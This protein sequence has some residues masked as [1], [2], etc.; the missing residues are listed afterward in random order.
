[1]DAVG[2]RQHQLI[3]TWQLRLLGVSDA[4]FAE[5]IA[6]GRWT[7][8]CPNVIALPG[9]MTPVRHLAA[10]VLS[11]APPHGA[12]L[13]VEECVERGLTRVQAMVYAAMGAGQIVCG[14][15]ALWLHG[16]VA[17]PAKPWVRIAT[18]SAG[19]SG[20]VGA[21]IRYGSYAGA[22]VW[23]S[24]LPVVEVEQ[25]F[26]DIPGAQEHP[27]AVWLHHDLTRLIAAADAKRATT[28]DLLDAAVA[29]APRFV[30]A[31]AIRRAIA[32]L[33]GE[34]VHSATER[35]ARRL[36]EA[37]VASFGLLLHERPYLVESNGVRVGEADLALVPIMLD[38]E[39]DGPH[40]RLPTQQEKDRARDRA[41]RRAGWE[42]ERFPTELIDVSPQRF[43]A[44]VA[45]CIAARIAVLGLLG[46]GGG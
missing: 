28:L 14:R 11:L 37:V 17:A 13:R 41:M 18:K 25:A 20:R 24:G 5:R 21:V 27:S 10:Q 19:T 7:R 16:I 29:A 39:I 4:A 32:D 9:D 34:L 45:Q 2:A 35:K 3:A 12:D 8:V 38:L 31:P 40:H 15:S 23:I 44:Q 43:K 26:M 22:V 30:G 46:L 42:V 33:R 1:V 6:A 36:C